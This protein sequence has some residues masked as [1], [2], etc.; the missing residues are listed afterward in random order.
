M[1]KLRARR[2]KLA[3]EEVSEHAQPET[4]NQALAGFSS[5]AKRERL[6]NFAWIDIVVQSF[7]LTPAEKHVASAIASFINMDPAHPWYGTGW[8]SQ[9]TIAHKL[10]LTVRTVNSSFRTLR[11]LGLIVVEEYAGWKYPMARTATHR[12]ALSSRGIRNLR[13]IDSFERRLLAAYIK[14]DD[15]ESSGRCAKVWKRNPAREEI[16]TDKMGNQRPQDRKSILT[17]NINYPYEI[18]HS[19]TSPFEVE[20]RVLCI[21]I[22]ADEGEDQGRKQLAKLPASLLHKYVGDLA[23]GTFTVRSLQNAS[24]CITESAKR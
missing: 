16:E 17:T 19:P 14:C 8:A 3:L 13:A 7:H 6:F 21:L 12:F 15:P 20:Y 18:D 11:R 24:S 9:N 23:D 2:R 5:D 22:G 4:L 1:R 10:N